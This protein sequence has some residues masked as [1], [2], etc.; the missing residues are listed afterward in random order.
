MKRARSLLWWVVTGAVC[1]YAVMALLQKPSASPDASSFAR[2]GVAIGGPFT[3]TDQNGDKVSDTQFRRKW[4]LVYFGFTSCPDVCP[5]DL[6]Q[7]SRAMDQLGADADK[8]A[9]LFISVDPERDTQ[10]QL[11]TFASNFSTRIIYLTGTP[12]EIKQA[13]SSY[14]VYAAKKEDKTSALGY[15]VDHS[16]FIYLMDR[17]GKYYAHFPHGTPAED[18]VKVIKEAVAK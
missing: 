2:E 3:L 4:M 12:E 9:P 5:T 15:T 6:L 10:Q 13:M 14:K 18:M 7:I 8:V 11:K 16:A 17:E 1:L